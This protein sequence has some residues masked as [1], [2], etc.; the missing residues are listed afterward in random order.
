MRKKPT[1]EELANSTLVKPAA[2]PVPIPYMPPH[3]A[4]FAA[5]ELRQKIAAMQAHKHVGAEYRAETTA[6]TRDFGVPRD[7]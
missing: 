1:F 7:F 3:G 4:T 2:A 6:A 5:T